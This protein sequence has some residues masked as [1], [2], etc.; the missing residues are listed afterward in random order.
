MYPLNC[1]R[2]LQ[3]GADSFKYLEVPA[4]L[5]AWTQWISGLSCHH[6]HK[7]FVIDQLFLMQEMG[8]EPS[9]SHMGGKLQASS[10]DSYGG[11]L[12]KNY[13]Y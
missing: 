8:S 10:F 1:S 9:I 12:H 6:N 2:I 5:L 7:V 4:N 3:A 11:S 13:S